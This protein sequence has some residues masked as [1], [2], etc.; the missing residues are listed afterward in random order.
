MDREITKKEFKELFY[1]YGVARK[2]SGWTEEYWEEVYERETNA[3]YFF[4]E[5]NSPGENRMFIDSGKGTHRIF[6][7][8]EEAEESLFQ[9]PES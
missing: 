9:S 7:L 4:T 5:P 1:K 3:R 8:T 6:L 2:Y